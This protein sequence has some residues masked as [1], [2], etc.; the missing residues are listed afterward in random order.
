MPEQE[1]KKKLSYE[2]LEAY[3][4]QTLAQAQQVFNENKR[5]VKEMNNLRSQQNYAEINLAFKIL[6]YK[7]FFSEECVRKVAARLEEVLTP[8]DNP[9]VEN[10]DKKPENN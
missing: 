8:Q 9:E 4:Q 7:D 10:P 3:A 2:E 1:E 6:E 5:L